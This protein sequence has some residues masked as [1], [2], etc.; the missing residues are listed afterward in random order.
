M[1]LGFDGD[2][3]KNAANALV[4]LNET[5]KTRR[6]INGVST[7]FDISNA[8]GARQF[9]MSAAEDVYANG[10]NIV[11]G[12]ISEVVYRSIGLVFESGD[13]GMLPPPVTRGEGSITHIAYFWQIL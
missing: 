3:L 2:N 7:A 6:N 5:G 11:V 1:A 8:D 4:A 12:S 10:G 9:L 13:M